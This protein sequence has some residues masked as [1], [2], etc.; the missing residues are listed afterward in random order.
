MTELVHLDRAAGV[1]TITLDSPSNRNALSPQ[2]QSELAAH[3]DTAARDDDVRAIVL[4]ATGTVFCSGADLKGARPSAGVTY[5]DLLLSLLHAPKPVIA[6][7][8]GAVRAGG[9][10]LVASCDIVV[11]PADATFAFA[12]VRIGV[13]PAIIGVV[14]L[15]RMPPLAASR[16]FLTGEVFTAAEA[17]TAGL[18]TIACPGDEVAARVAALTTEIRRT[19]PGAVAE[20]KRLLTELPAHSLADGFELA[21]V[22]SAR[23]FASDEAQA[24][25]AA[26]RERR[27]PPWDP[28]AQEG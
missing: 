21:A 25:I 26:F 19:A 11:A 14:C 3:L 15:R 10:G 18:V 24:G 9:I 27:P 5:P 17:V 16:Y 22:T 13:A 23:L 7:L 4:T 1:T 2:L 6:A 28:A 20:T 8:N 12:E